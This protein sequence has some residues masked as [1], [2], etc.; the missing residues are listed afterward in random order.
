MSK[1]VKVGKYR[2]DAEEFP[3][4]WQF[5][6]WVPIESNDPDSGEIFNFMSEDAKDL[7]KTIKTLVDNH[8][9]HLT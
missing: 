4:G 3:D 2:G 7:L 1:I 5:T 8:E 6:V 9:A